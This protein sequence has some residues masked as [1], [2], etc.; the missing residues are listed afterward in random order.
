MSKVIHLENIADLHHLLQQPKAKHPLLSVVDFTQFDEQFGA[1]LKMS[2]GFYTIM[3]KNY[4]VNAI[5]YGRQHYDFQEGS[6][7]CIAPKQVVTLDEAVEKRPDAMGWGIFF[8]P[9]LIR[10]TALGK[11]IKNY[12][13]FSYETSEALHLSEKEEQTLFDCVQKINTELSENIDRHSQTLLVSNLELLLNYCVR[14]Y[15]R[16]FITRNQ[17][18]KDILSKVEEVLSSYFQS[19]NLHEMGLPTVKYLA[20]QVFL[21]PN[22]LS[23]LLKRET[24]M[25][26]QDRIH[27]YLI[28]EAKNL[29]LSSDQ[30][31][32]ELAFG[33][34][35]EYPQYFSRLFK[36]K[37]GMTPVEF[38]NAN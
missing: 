5:K 27:Y 21:S 24:G 13:F 15:D 7:M 35:F 36:A 38:R 23:D 12:S 3:Y 22:Y 31:V 14:Y 11:N 18:N 26:A 2:S 37:T 33:L 28:E 1:G 9:D 4:C 17:A 20:D 16:Q 25:N 19:T 34:G 32:S 29:L 6:L 30:S 8:H 10:G